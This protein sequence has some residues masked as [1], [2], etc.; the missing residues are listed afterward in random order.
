MA[1]P[2]CLKI[3]D[4]GATAWNAWRAQNSFNPVDL[5][6][7]NVAGMNL[8]GIELQFADLAQANLERTDL[9]YANFASSFLRGVNLYGATLRGASL[10]QALLVNANLRETSLFQTNLTAA[11][12]S[13]ADMS[14]AEMGMTVLAALD[15]SA[16]IGLDTI[17]HIARSTVDIDTI[18]ESTGNIPEVF[19]RGCGLPDDFIIYMRSLVDKPIE[20]NS[21]FISYSSKDQ[22]FAQCLY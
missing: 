13:Y 9:S 10:S 18:Y 16:V 6:E 21:C 14:N 11:L 2:E 1:N 20:F 19:L 4:Q 15:L 22:D 17:K 7:A 3:L 5:R 8:R 12:L